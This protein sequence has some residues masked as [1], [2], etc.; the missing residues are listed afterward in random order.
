M[1]FLDLGMS[2][3]N[4][5]DHDETA[6]GVKKTWSEIMKDKREKY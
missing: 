4:V 1:W 3:V 6:E 5:L 2:E